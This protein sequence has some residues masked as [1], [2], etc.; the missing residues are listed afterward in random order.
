MKVEEAYRTAIATWA[1][2]V[3]EQINPDVAHVF[4]RS[5]EPSHWRKMTC[6]NSTGPV[7]N[8]T[9]IEPTGH[10][11]QADALDD[12]WDALQVRANFLNITSLSTLR[13][14]GHIFKYSR[15]GPPMDCAHWCLPGVPDTWNELLYASLLMKLTG[16][17]SV[18]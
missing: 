9:L 12:I 16:T 3:N 11:M 5:F 17:G 10:Y 7:T 13:P 2:W 8:K 18:Y 15:G 1:A 4:F 6:L 14:D